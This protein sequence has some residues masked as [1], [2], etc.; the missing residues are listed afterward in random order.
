MAIEEDRAI[1]LHRYSSRASTVQGER[2]VMA[3]YDHRPHGG[4]RV[5]PRSHHRLG[6][7]GRLS[8]HQQDQDASPCGMGQ[9][10][11]VLQRGEDAWQCDFEANGIVDQ[12][13]KPSA[14]RT[15]AAAPSVGI[16]LW[17]PGRDAHLMSL[18]PT[19]SS[20]HNLSCPTL[21]FLHRMAA[22]SPPDCPLGGV[23]GR[24]WSS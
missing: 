17:A 10:P 14:Q 1:Q 6:V 11:Q 3:G 16:H 19:Y 5:Q 9:K 20:P 4:I 8:R 23:F 21:L 7:Y 18:Q 2:A 12:S 22:T 15:I 24:Y 13:E